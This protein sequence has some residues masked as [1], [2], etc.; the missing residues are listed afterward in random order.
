[1]SRLMI[2]AGLSI[3]LWSACGTDQTELPENGRFRLVPSSESGI[4]F[5]NHLSPSEHWNI[6][7]Y[8]YYYNGAGVSVGDLDGDG[9]PELFFTANESTNRLYRNMGN[10]RFEEITEEAGILPGGWSTGTTM[11]DVN[12]DGWLDI[13]VCQVGKYRGRTERNQLYINKGDGTF[14]EQAEAYGLDFSGL[15]TQAAFFDY[16]LDGDL[17]L[18]LLNH[19]VHS[20]NSYGP[21]SK[22]KETDAMSGDRLYRN[23]LE[24]AGRFTDVTGEAG[25]YSSQLGYGL[26]IAVTDYNADGWPDLYISNDFHEND[27]LYHN[28]GD[29]T[30]REVGEQVFG[31]TSRYSMGNEAADVNN[32]GHIDILSLDML[33]GDPYVL[34]KSAAEDRAEVSEIKRKYGY[35]P[36]YVR[37]SLQI[38]A[39]NGSFRDLAP[40][41]GVYATDWSW[42]ALVLDLENDGQQDIYITNGIVR[43]PNDLDYIQYLAALERRREEPPDAEMAGNMPELKIPN[44]AFHN[45]GGVRFSDSTRAYGLDI[46]S[47]SNGAAYGDLDGDGD[48]DLVVNNINDEAFLWENKEPEGN[49]LRVALKHPG[50]NTNGLGARLELYAGGARQV[51]ELYATRGFLSSVEPVAHFGLG[52]RTAADSLLVYWPGH[53]VQRIQHLG[54]NRFY[55]VQ[56][57]DGIMK[58][59]SEPEY[60]RAMQSGSEMDWLAPPIHSVAWTHRE[61]AYRDYSR[62]PL[63]PYELSMEGPAVAVGDLNGDGRDDLF[64]GSAHGEPAVLFLQGADGFEKLIP[65]VFMEDRDYEDVDAAFADVDGDGD[66]DLYVVSGGNQYSQGNSLLRDRLYLNENGSLLSSSR[67]LMDDAVNGSTVVFE[68][69]DRDGL[70][71]AFIGVRSLPGMYGAFAESYLLRNNG[72]GTLVRDTQFTLPGMVTDAVWFDEDGDGDMDLAVAGDWMPITIIENEKGLLTGNRKE[73]GGT[74]GWWRSVAA[75]DLNGDGRT[76]LIAGNAGLNMKLRASE[77]QPVELLLN[78]L[79]GNGQPDPVLFYWV[80]GVKIPFATKDEL[81]KQVPVFRKNFA[82]YE[83][84]AL[85]NDLQGVIKKLNQ[86]TGQLREVQTFASVWLRNDGEGFVVTELPEKAQWSAVQDI[87]VGKKRANGTVPVILGGNSYAMNINLGQLDAMPGIRLEFL[88]NGTCRPTGDFD[89]E[90]IHGDVRA[91]KSLLIG[92]EQHLVIALN[93]GPVYLKRM[94]QQQ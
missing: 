26:G 87:F 52:E 82:S 32:D 74:A 58:K 23:D 29:G 47:F 80:N 57:G 62:E 25:I 67:I 17:D 61:N 41:A 12:G 10:L 18:Y 6:I 64:L 84:Y 63:I 8:L 34:R 50:A 39:G 66:L 16:D 60:Q 83:D 72:K 27:Y 15:S 5:T 2:I 68:D 38:N 85:E 54:A 76:D 43:R 91:V 35:A 77:D 92:T 89:S 73:I 81:D 90:G 55:T 56:Y 28:E 3:C 14:S 37:N 71:E 30:F 33:P 48:L 31:H 93:N 65:D 49:Y 70:P 4:Q 88:E 44:Y 22:R 7:D 78:D 69:L 79:D 94:N 46:P 86:E 59:I 51:R 42:G 21:A 24:D 36:Q 13:Y 11:A 9:L 1:M 45:L 53:T 19:S 75:A 20:V 40:W